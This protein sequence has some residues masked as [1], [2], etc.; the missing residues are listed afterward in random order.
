MKIGSEAHKELFCRSFIESH[1]EYDPS[2]LLW[3]DLDE[4]ALKRLQEIPFWQ[5]ALNTEQEAGVMVSACA[6]TISDPLIR[7]AIALQGREEARHGQLI[8]FVIQRYGIKIPELP[9]ASVPDNIEQAFIDFGYGECVDSF[10][11]FGLFKIARQSEFLPEQIFTIFDLILQEEASHIV[12]FV[13]WVAYLQAS[14]GQGAKL[15]RGMHSLWHYGRAVQHLLGIVN[16][17]SNSNGEGFTATGAS[18]FTD[19]LSLD[20]FLSTCIQENARRMR[21]FDDRLIRPQL[22]P[23]LSKI[24]LSATKLIAKGNPR[25]DNK[26]S[27]SEAE[28]S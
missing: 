24:A 8:K 25:S 12:F 16:S 6:A 5:A 1:K 23:T 7:E 18:A 26:N 4:T 2:K 11:A 22:L 14:K 3:P 19:D 9:P 20:M 21:S 27:L 28:N 10:L 15:F 17:S 13:N